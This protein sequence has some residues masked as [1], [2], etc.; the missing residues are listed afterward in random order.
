MFT[1]ISDTRPVAMLLRI[2]VYGLLSLTFTQGCGGTNQVHLDLK[3]VNS[4]P[5]PVT[6]VQV[7][8]LRHTVRFGVVGKGAGATYI[9]YDQP[10]SAEAVVRWVDYLSAKHEH[11]LTL[12]NVYPVGS[13]VS[14]V[15]I[16]DILGEKAEAR[17]KASS[18]K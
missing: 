7:A 8:F 3:V 16:V 9:D 17:F 4:S 1:T 2:L 11:K 13:R 5:E 6:N 10:L 18:L 12:K 14:G 15:L